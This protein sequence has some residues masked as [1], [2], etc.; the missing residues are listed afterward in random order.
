MAAIVSQG[1]WVKTLE[2]ISTVMTDTSRSWIV[3][4]V[5]TRPTDAFQNGKGYKGNVKLKWSEYKYIQ[6]VTDAK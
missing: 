2:V 3:F 6:L 5:I 1:R 4:I